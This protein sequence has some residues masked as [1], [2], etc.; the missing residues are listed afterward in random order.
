[1]VF[2]HQPLRRPRRLIHCHRGPPAHQEISL[3][4]VQEPCKTSYTTSEQYDRRRDYFRSDI[5][6]KILCDPSFVDDFL[7]GDPDKL[8]EVLKSCLSNPSYDPESKAWRLPEVTEHAEL[9]KPILDI[10]NA[11][12][13]AVDEQEGPDV[14]SPLFIDIPARP[15]APNQSDS[16][17]MG[18]D[19]GLFIGSQAEWTMLRFPVEVKAQPKSLKDAILELTWDAGMILANQFFRRHLYGLVVCGSE[20]TFVRFDRAG[21]LHSRPIDI[22]TSS[23]EFTRAFASMLLL[24]AT[25]AGY[26]NAFTVVPNQNGT[27]Q[28]Y[29]D[30]PEAAFSDAPVDPNTQSSRDDAN[31]AIPT[32]RFRVMRQLYVH[33]DIVGRATVVYQIRDLRKYEAQSQNPQ[34]GSDSTGG[35]KRKAEVL[36]EA[37]MSQ[38]DY[39]LKL[40]WRDPLEGV[41]GE[42]MKEVEGMYGL[43]QYVWHCDVAGACRC[44]KRAEGTCGKCFDETPQPSNLERS[45][46]MSSK[47]KEAAESGMYLPSVHSSS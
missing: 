23:D 36:D 46:I 43:P 21:I 27:L 8:A 7:T 6:N 24:D 47:S 37:V 20:A 31:D 38:P 19:L 40:M 35:K 39:I 10:L 26:D 13:N 3:E 16:F 28:L 12:K 17:A 11:I 14:K 30:L 4:A 18:P 34:S 1:M 41:E 44:E 15:I 22:R 29:I 45:Y 5:G 2:E 25:A 9:R 32:R 33:G 42:V